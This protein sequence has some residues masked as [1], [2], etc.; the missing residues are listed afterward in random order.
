MIQKN[1]GLE[2]LQSFFWIVV[3]DRLGLWLLSFRLISR[4]KP[5]SSM[6]MHD[7]DVALEE[8]KEENVKKLRI[9]NGG[10]ESST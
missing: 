6:D 9:K 8:S 2:L 7:N 3:R 4:M 10:T 5:L 1:D